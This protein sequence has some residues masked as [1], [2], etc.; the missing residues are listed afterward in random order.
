M[1][2]LP[3]HMHA[4]ACTC[5]PVHAGI[6]CGPWICPGAT[7]QHGWSA[8]SYLWNGPHERLECSRHPGQRSKVKGHSCHMTHCLEMGVR[9]PWS[10]P[11]EEY[12]D[13]DISLGGYHGRPPA[14]HHTW[15]RAGRPHTHSRHLQPC[16]CICMYVCLWCRWSQ[17]HCLTFSNK[18]LI[19]LIFTWKLAFRVSL[20][21]ERLEVDEGGGGGVS[22]W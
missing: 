3:V 2:S 7:C 15:P 19:L 20:G 11:G 17:F 13:H 21:G 16:A 18:L 12:G 4:H 22:E 9:S 5:T 1:Q 10:F 8:G 6:L 14:L